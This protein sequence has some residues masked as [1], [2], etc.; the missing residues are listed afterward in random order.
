MIRTF[1]CALA[2]L[3]VICPIANGGLVSFVDISQSTQTPGDPPNLYGPANTSTPNQLLFM[4]PSGFSAT[5]V[6]AGG[7]DITDGLLTFSVVVDDPNMTWI[8]DFKFSENGTWSLV[9]SVPGFAGLGTNV[10]N[11]ILGYVIITSVNG[12]A[13]NG[14]TV[15]LSGA[16][17]SFD[18]DSDLP[19]GDGFW[20]NMAGQAL[21][22]GQFGRVT[23]IDVAINN[24]LVAFSEGGPEG[25]SIAFIDKKRITI[26]VTTEMVPE[27]AICLLAAISVSA[28][29]LTRTRF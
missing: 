25:T 27:P 26:R 18:G 16:A 7:A 6:G 5:A 11:R 9:E 28:V 12:V 8:T 2:F 21:P 17:V 22:V 1:C 29:L 23:S 4:S 13:V 15:P 14:P 10:R 20:D 24:R 3:A 19:P